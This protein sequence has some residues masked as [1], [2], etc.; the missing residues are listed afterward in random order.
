MAPTGL[1]S[2]AWAGLGQAYAMR[3]EHDAATAAVA[4]YLSLAPVQNRILEPDSR[5]RILLARYAVGD[6]RLAE[7][8]EEYLTWATREGHALGVLFLRHLLIVC[9]GPGERAELLPALEVAAMGIEG[10]IPAAML[11]HAEALIAGDAGMIGAG[12]AG[13]AAVGIWLPTPARLV[14]LTQ[15]QREIA[16]LAGAGMSN[17][18]IAHKLHIWPARSTPTWGISS[19]A[20]ELRIVRNWRQPWRADPKRAPHP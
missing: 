8:L 15:R 16:A 11:R 20:W 7:Y 12:V 9:A 19:G 17:K 6:P 2:M 5:Y 14:S 10:L 1:E 18:A 4:Q 13:L 3:G